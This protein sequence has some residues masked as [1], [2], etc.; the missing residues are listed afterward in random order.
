V[1]KWWDAEHERNSDKMLSLCLDL[2]GFYLKAGQFLGT[3]PDFMPMPYIVRRPG[4]PVGLGRGGGW[5]TEAC[6]CR[7]S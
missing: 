7:R 5:V 4:L 3:R 6:G 2:R 1:Q